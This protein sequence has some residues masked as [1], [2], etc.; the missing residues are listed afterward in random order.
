MEPARGIEPRTYWLRISL[1]SIVYFHVKADFINREIPSVIPVY[2]YSKNK[3]GGFK[4]S[5]PWWC[6]ESQQIFL[7]FSRQNESVGQTNSLDR[8]AIQNMSR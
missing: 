4:E 8:S 5:L 2:L 1:L 7:A 6:S 3:D